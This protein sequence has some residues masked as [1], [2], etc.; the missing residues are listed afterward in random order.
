MDKLLFIR[1]I[2]TGVIIGTILY[3]VVA[4]NSVVAEEDGPNAK[5]CKAPGVFVVRT[6]RTI[7]TAY[8]P[9]PDETDDTP[10]ITAYGTR[11]RD[12]IVATNLLRRGTKIRIP[13]VFGYEKIFTVE[14]TM[15][16]DRYHVDILMMTK[17]EAKDFGVKWGPNRKGVRVEI[18]EI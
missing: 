7:L 15:A 6:F 13:E 18:L 10:F 5:F 1:A 9:S 14:D 4:P 17:K 3:G 16:P 12:G 8:S 2:V 11:V